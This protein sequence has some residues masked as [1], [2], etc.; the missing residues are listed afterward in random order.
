MDGCARTAGGA[1]GWAQGWAIV[2]W[3]W[4]AVAVAIVIAI[5]AS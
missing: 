1:G 5:L 3:F 4:T 2:G